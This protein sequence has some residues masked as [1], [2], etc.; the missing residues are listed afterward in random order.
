MIRALFQPRNPVPEDVYA[1]LVR[2]LFTSLPQVLTI[3]ISTSVCGVLLITRSPGDLWYVVLTAV[4]IA[5]GVARPLMIVAYKRQ[6]DKGPLGTSHTRV[7]ERC[8]GAGSIL[9]GAISSALAVHAMRL[10]D[11]PGHVLVAGLVLAYTGGLVGR[12]AV[13]PWIC[14]ATCAALMVPFIA[15]CAR[16]E[17]PLFPIFA[18]FLGLYSLSLVEAT[19]HLYGTILERLL[20]Q[21][22]LERMARHDPLT[23]LANRI[24]LREELA[25]F[26]GRSRRQGSRFAVLC[27]DLDRFK[28]VNDTLGHR[29]GDALLC[30]VADRLRGIVTGSDVV[31]RVGGDEFVILHA[32]VEA[33]GEASA[34]AQRLVDALGAPYRIDGHEVVIGASVGIA[35]APSD[36]AE[37]DRLLTSA[38]EALYRAKAQGRGTW[39]VY[40][41]PLPARTP[42]RSVDPDHNLF[43]KAAPA[44][45]QHAPGAGRLTSSKSGPPPMPALMPAT[46]PTGSGAISRPGRRVPACAVP[47]RS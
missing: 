29:A 17:D 45:A 4:A 5:V 43:G 20:A 15:V 39:R 32:L 24:S 8:Y 31:A 7:W 12:V 37:A 16:R 3:S 23:E 13:R 44:F 34:L 18:G 22:A 47:G 19:R 28:T 46:G 35:I 11:G 27:L 40:G 33:D 2:L 38:D 14:L 42:G 30:A 9:Y 21:R 41:D 36:G 25:A 6:T 26:L 10:E 1:E